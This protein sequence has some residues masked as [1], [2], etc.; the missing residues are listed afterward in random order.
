MSMKERIKIYLSL[1]SDKS[2]VIFFENLMAEELP[3]LISSN[4]HNNIIFDQLNMPHL[5]II[6]L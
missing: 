5:Q 3:V 4:K 1:H 6:E 2:K